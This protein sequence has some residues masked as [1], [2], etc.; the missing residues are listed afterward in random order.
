MTCAEWATRLAALLAAE[1]ASLTGAKVKSQADGVMGLVYADMDLAALQRAIGQARSA[2]DR[3]NGCA[4]AR[5]VVFHPID[6]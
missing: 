3:C 2:V 1:L 5:G 4:R 6:R